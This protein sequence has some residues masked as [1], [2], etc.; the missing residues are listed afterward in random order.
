MT[1]DS[2]TTSTLIFQKK[3]PQTN[4]KTSRAG[5]GRSPGYLDDKRMP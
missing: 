5:L 2:T 4:G 1:E 3:T